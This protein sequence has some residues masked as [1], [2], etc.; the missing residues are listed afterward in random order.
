MVCTERKIWALI[1][2]GICNVYT[3]FYYL[4]G[5]GGSG[6]AVLVGVRFFE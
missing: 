6:P 5:D 3:H 4:W 1:S 2:R